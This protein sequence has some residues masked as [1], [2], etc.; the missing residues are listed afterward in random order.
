MTYI[1]V[2]HL[3]ISMCHSG[4]YERFSAKYPFLRTQKIMYSP[5]V[6]PYCRQYVFRV[7]NNITAACCSLH[8]LA[9]THVQAV[10]IPRFYI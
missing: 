4:G 7:Q 5:L 8:C 2:D 9:Q 6:S 3:S 1:Y 10:F